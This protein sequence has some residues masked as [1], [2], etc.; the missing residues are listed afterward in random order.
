MRKH[1]GQSDLNRPDKVI[2]SFGLTRFFAGNNSIV[3]KM[4]MAQSANILPDYG[5]G[6]IRYLPIH[7]PLSK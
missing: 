5:P 7:I 1:R 4:E 3:H 6:K 2:L